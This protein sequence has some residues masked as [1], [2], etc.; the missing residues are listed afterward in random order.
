MFFPSLLSHDFHILP[1]PKTV[2]RAA[3]HAK[4]MCKYTKYTFSLQIKS[5]YPN[6]PCHIFFQGMFHKIFYPPLFTISHSQP[7]PCPT[8][9]AQIF[10]SK[11]LKSSNTAV[12]ML[13]IM[14]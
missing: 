3:V 4:Q 1:Y 11:V 7:G 8:G 2:R 12:K 10:H 13:G 9:F 6:S 5:A 14:T